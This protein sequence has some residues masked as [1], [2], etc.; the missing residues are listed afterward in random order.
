MGSRRRRVLL[1]NLRPV[2]IAA[3]D[4]IMASDLERRPF[5]IVEDTIT[6]RFV[7]F[8]RLYKPKTGELCFDVP[9]LGINMK[10]CPD[11]KTGADWAAETL[12][13]NLD[14]PASAELVV[15]IDG[16]ETN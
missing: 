16:D 5:V 6:K 7:Q 10:P 2:L 14:L 15:K 11:P 3:L 8:A 12:A 13:E 4:E 1:R 9:K